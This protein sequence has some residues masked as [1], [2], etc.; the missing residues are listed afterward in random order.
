MNACLDPGKSFRVR[1]MTIARRRPQS[2]AG[3][4]SKVTPPLY[5]LLNGKK[6]QA[7]HCDLSNRL[8]AKTLITTSAGRLPSVTVTELLFFPFSWLLLRLPFVAA[9]GVVAV[10]VP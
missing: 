1:M 6:R 4:F 3:S 10:H 5:L 8:C 2:D 9:D 7:R